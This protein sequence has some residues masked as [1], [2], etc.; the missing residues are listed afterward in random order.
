MCSIAKLLSKETYLCAKVKSRIRHDWD[1]G[2][3]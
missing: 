3:V 1:G 2:G